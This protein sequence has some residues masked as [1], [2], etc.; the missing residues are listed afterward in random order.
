MARRIVL[1]GATGY[2][3][4]LVAAAM[5]RAGARPVLAGRNHQS[6]AAVGVR[7]GKGLDTVLADIAHPETLLE[8]VRPG[9]VLVSTVGPFTRYGRAVVEAAI[10]RRATYFDCTGEAPF[11]RAM[12]E[13][14][15]PIADQAGTALF[16]AFAYEFVAGEVAA[17]LALDGLAEATRV[18]V[19]YFVRGG[20]RGFT[21]AGTRASVSGVMLAPNFAWRDG[22]LRPARAAGRK[23]KFS[24]DGKARLALS[25]AGAEHFTVPRV[26][27]QVSDIGVFL[28][29]IGGRVTTRA[30]GALFRAGSRI[31]GGRRAADAAVRVVSHREGP[32]EEQRAARGSEVIAVASDAA[33]RELRT[34][35]LRG[36]NAYDF[37]AAILAW[38]AVRVTQQ[39]IERSGALG[40]VEAFGL[41]PLRDACAAAG[42]PV[43]DEA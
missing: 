19:G 24:I 17:A 20:Y 27:P 40:A 9:D 21:S 36:G 37:T 7:L 31:P 8:L 43:V 25:I 35:R 10:Y 29:G 1:L 4:R 23:R 2:T 30:A 13:E 5:V 38:G 41:A 15:S 42:L 6:L 34:V 39:G 11:I 32:D 12:H 33:G 18:D 22:A 28:G 14:L 26:F 16:T 3:G